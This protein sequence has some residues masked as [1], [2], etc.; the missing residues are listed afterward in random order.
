MTHEDQVYVVN[1]VVT[2]LTR[3]TVVMNVISR[4]LSVV[5]KFNA[6]AKIHKYRRFHEVHHFTPMA[7]E[8]HGI[9]GHDMDHFIR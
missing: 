6:S 1:V 9:F 4:P 3:K 5:V 8:V 7:M 2:N